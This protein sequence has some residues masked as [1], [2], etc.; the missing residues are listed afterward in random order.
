MIS[1]REGVL[2]W[3]RWR[4]R[5]QHALL[6]LHAGACER[7]DKK[8][9]RR[10]CGLTFRRG[11]IVV[12]LTLATWI[13]VALLARHGSISPLATAL[14]TSPYLG[15]SATDF[16]P[17]A[18][19]PP[20][21]VVVSLTTT[22]ARLDKVMDSVNSLLRQSLV[23]DQIYVNI[24]KGP[25][26]RK[27]TRSYDDVEIPSSLERLSPLVRINRCVD[28]G[29]ATKLLGALRQENDPSTLI[30]TVDDDFEYP[31]QLVEALSWEA[32]FRPENVHG[33]CGWGIMPMEWHSVGAVPAYVPYF[34][35]PTGRYVD[36]LQACCG[37][38]YRRGFF[39]NLTELADMPSVCVTVD[40]VWIAG[41]LRMVENRRTA[42]ISKRLDPS[43]PSWKDIESQSS[44]SQLKLSAFNHENQVH[45][46]CIQA[47]E[48]RFQMHWTRNFEEPQTRQKVVPSPDAPQQHQ[49]RTASRTA[50]RIGSRHATRDYLRDIAELPRLHT[51]TPIVPATAAEIAETRRRSYWRRRLDVWEAERDDPSAQSRK[52]APGSICTLPVEVQAAFRRKVLSIFAL[53]L[54]LLTGLLALL[55]YEPSLAELMEDAFPTAWYLLIALLVVVVMLYALY[56]AHAWFPVNWIALLLFSVSLSVLIAGVQI[57][58]DTRA[59]LFCCVFTFAAVCVMALLCGVKRIVG[60]T[61]VFLAPMVAGF[62]S[63]AM[64]AIVSAVIQGAVWK[65][66]SISALGSSRQT[67]TCT[68]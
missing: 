28:D 17:P 53:Q 48:T 67:S 12:I 23:P 5:V 56:V 27:P 24:P 41:Y 57:V 36:V 33:V 32:V 10:Q 64:V 39:H 65:Y 54:L 40:D 68:A 1:P 14:Y 62:A 31:T 7:E 55:T 20:F 51:A 8:P 38:A 4:V 3:Q 37:N 11:F 22:P 25:M 26:K 45:H 15:R 18:W 60:Q 29:P 47:M 35:R 59:G 63:F 58:L 44:A 42:L 21:R 49:T 16:P 34:M 6:P 2:A 43:D 13:Y 66:V 50:S 46:K 30:I 9:A 52:F 61:T 19:R